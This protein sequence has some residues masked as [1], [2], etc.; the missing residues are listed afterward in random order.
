MV[1]DGDQA[2]LK[3]PGAPP[4]KFDLARDAVMRAVFDQLLLWVGS[5]NLSGA[6]ADY[7]LAAGGGDD[8]P[9]LT[10]TPKAGGAIARAFARIELRFDRDMLLKGIALVERNGDEKTITFTKMVRNPK[11]PAD[12][13]AP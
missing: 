4:Q 8:A 3:T 5:S 11:L 1:L 13:F 10:L 12:A 6:A 2:T 7:D 9:T